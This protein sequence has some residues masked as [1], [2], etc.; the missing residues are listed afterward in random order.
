[1]NTKNERL[2]AVPRLGPLFVS[3]VCF[4]VRSHCAAQCAKCC[5]NSPA[6]RTPLPKWPLQ[7]ILRIHPPAPRDGQ[8]VRWPLRPLRG[9]MRDNAGLSIPASGQPSTP[10]P[11]VSNFS[12]PATVLSQIGR[13]GRNQLFPK[14]L[15]HVP[16]VSKAVPTCPNRVTTVTTCHS[17]TPLGQGAC[18]QPLLGAGS[19][20]C[21]Y[22][23]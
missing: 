18:H 5:A 19:P 7:T 14:H 16:A 17:V 10:D 15:W 21:S 23:L 9:A 20:L 13:L 12:N 2:G 22:K 3:F 6:W 11:N 1:M 8:G 4:V